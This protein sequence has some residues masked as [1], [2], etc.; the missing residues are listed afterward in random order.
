MCRYRG[1]KTSCNITYSM[2]G[3]FSYKTPQS[4]IGG[5]CEND[6]VHSM[7]GIMRYV[8]DIDYRNP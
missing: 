5:N 7:S 6:R 2:D 1:V 3:F 4:N 8:N